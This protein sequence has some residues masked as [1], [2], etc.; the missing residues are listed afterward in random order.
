M[1]LLNILI[2]EKKIILP[3]EEEIEKIAELCNGNLNLVEY[4][5][6]ET[7]AYGKSYLEILEKL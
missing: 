4:L 6:E 3:Q 1:I 2:K 7:I 5:D